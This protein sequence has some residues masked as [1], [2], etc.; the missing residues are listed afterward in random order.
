MPVISIK[1]IK[2]IEQEVKNQKLFIKALEN[3]E[4][5]YGS[6]FTE[7]KNKTQESID[8]YNKMLKEA[9]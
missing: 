6:D 9:A 5:N 4:K 2:A 7:E 3:Q 8:Y 1:I